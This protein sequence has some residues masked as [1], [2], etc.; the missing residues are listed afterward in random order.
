MEQLPLFYAEQLAQG[1]SLLELPAD[2]ARHCVQV[3]RMKKGDKLQLTDGK[4]YFYHA[5]ITETGKKTASVAVQG[6]EYVPPARKRISV[7]ISLLKNPGRLEW[8]LEKA[9][10]IG[11]QE[12]IPLVCHRTERQHFRYDRMQAILAAAMVQSRQAWFPILSQ[13]TDIK[14]VIANATHACRLIAHCGD[15]EKAAIGSFATY[16]DIQIL[17]GPEGDFTPDEVA[18]AL[19]RQY[20]PVS[21]GQTRLRTETAGMVATALLRIPY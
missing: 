8:F 6:S 21:L 12:I 9:T 7:G 4:G 13:P 11:V 17:I 15:G 5:V 3:L 16:N 2:V 19:A 18:F 1:K 10:E 20:Q 14:L